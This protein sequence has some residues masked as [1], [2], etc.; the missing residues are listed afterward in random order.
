MIFFSLALLIAFLRFSAFLAKSI[1]AMISHERLMAR[2]RVGMR[3]GLFPAESLSLQVASK[4]WKEAGTL[5]EE[6][7][8]KSFH[9][10]IQLFLLCTR[11]KL[12]SDSCREGTQATKET[13][14]PDPAGI[15]GCVSC[16]K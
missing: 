11:I 13:Y 6:A 2:L 7:M 10:M 8:K 16:R 3:L 12:S 15:S 5:N 4:R 1:K 14:R 9:I